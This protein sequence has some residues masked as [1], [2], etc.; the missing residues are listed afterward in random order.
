MLSLNYIG[1]K[2]KLLK[3]LNYVFKD[4]I[5]KNILFGDLCSGT[6]IVS[7]FVQKTYKCK[8]IANDLQSFSTTITKALLESYNQDDIKEIKKH[9]EIMNKLK[10]TNGFFVKNFENKYFNTFNCKKIDTMRNYIEKT[11]LNDKIKT[12]LLASLITS[13]DK[14]ANTTSVYGAY[15][16][17]IKESAKKELVLDKLPDIQENYE[18]KCYNNDLFDIKEKFDLI[19]IDPP[20]NNRQFGSNYHILE[21]ICKN[22]E[23]ELKGK[24]LLREYEKS[25]FCYKSEIKNMFERIKNELDYKTLILSYSNKGLLKLFDICDIFIEN[26]NI[27]VYEIDYKKFKANKNQNDGNVVEYVIVF[28][29]NCDRKGEN[30]IT[31]SSLN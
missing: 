4:Y 22:D 14:V 6:G 24:T 5:T 3:Y 12:F 7:N 16:K 18:F 1:S 17:K 13:A 26:H 19:Y 9:F 25:K 2:K 15:L 11:K 23:P 28:C 29:R 10:L 31:I 30:T 21:T 27:L 20:Y 8:V